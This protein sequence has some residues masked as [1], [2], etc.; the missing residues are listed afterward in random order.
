MRPKRGRYRITDDGRTVDKHNLDEYSEKD[1]LEWPVWVAYQ[2]EIAARKL[3]SNTR[4]EAV[5]EEAADPLEMM[6]A[7]ERSFNAK[8]ETDLRKRLQ[9]SSPE[10]F[11]KAVIEVLGLRRRARREAARW[12]LR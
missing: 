1:M 3:G 5:T 10:F 9:T 8:T 2:E 7:G 6:A 12:A 4:S 11:E